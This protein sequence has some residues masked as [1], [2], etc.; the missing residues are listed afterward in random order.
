MI[1]SKMRLTLCIACATVFAGR[2]SFVRSSL[3][4]ESIPRFSGCAIPIGSIS[5]PQLRA[6]SW[7]KS[8]LCTIEDEKRS[9]RLLNFGCY[10]EDKESLRV[11]GTKK[12]TKD[13]IN[14]EK[15]QNSV[16]ICTCIIFRKLKTLS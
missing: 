2:G 9:A 8:K 11:A 1:G 15:H 6:T 16:S 12:T 4:V 7:H 13:E 14:D 5:P 3:R 10:D